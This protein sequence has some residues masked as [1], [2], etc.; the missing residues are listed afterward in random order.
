ML[1]STWRGI[2]K[3]TKVSFAAPCFI[4]LL[5]AQ[6]FAATPLHDWMMDDASGD[7]SLNWLNH[8]SA[9]IHRADAA[10]D[11]QS[12][13]TAIRAGLATN[14][15]QQIDLF[16]EN[17]QCAVSVKTF[18]AS[19]EGRYAKVIE[20][21][22][23]GHLPYQQTVNFGNDPIP[24]EFG[25]LHD[26]SHVHGSHDHASAHR[27]LDHDGHTHV[28]FDITSV[29]LGSNQSIGLKLHLNVSN[30]ANAHSF[31]L[32]GLGALVSVLSA[33]LL[34]AAERFMRR[35]QKAEEMSLEKAQY[36]AE[37]D[38]LTG[39]FN[40]YGFH[41]RA[42]QILEND[43]NLGAQ[44]Y[45]VI[46]D[47]D[48]FKEVNDQHGHETGDKVL[49]EVA[50]LLRDSY[51]KDALFGRLGGDE[52][53]VFA[54][55]VSHW[56]NVDN[57]IATRR[58]QLNL[59]LPHS[60][61]G[62]ETSVS[63]G[64]ARFPEHG[65]DLVDLMQAA[66]LALLEVKK[67]SKSTIGVYKAAMKERFE[68]RIWE[69]Q[70]VRLAA[71]TGQIEAHYQPIVSAQT[72]KICLFEALARWKHPTQGILPPGAFQSALDDP[73]VS[74][75]ITS[76]MLDCVAR[77]LKE[78]WGQNVKIPVSLN[79]GQADLKNPE[80]PDQMAAALDRYELPPSAL[81]VEVTETAVAASNM[82]NVLSVLDKIRT[83][84]IEI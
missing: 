60:D 59:N 75:L 14:A 70:G 1:A 34:F 80:L 40:R 84:D 28:I 82:A 73:I 11:Y 30:A 69:M 12:L 37:H 26:E 45:L 42:Q 53:A 24:F 72:S 77:D 68:R 64:Y 54:R 27:L 55:S 58:T 50:K 3:R 79:L 56:R 47:A 4:V 43:A 21:L 52:F 17:C 41:T 76:A 22:L 65:T 81:M 31:M 35:S 57:F 61:R 78:W 9:E 44:G 71:E 83:R 20:R 36:L 10:D 74:R 25:R 19:E 33:I 49:V 63:A 38:P 62:L 8:F 39:F 67:N 2:R 51:P 5:V 13:T 6:Y 23:K 15:L 46:Y 18:P 16:N 7:A 32:F 66:D 29:T 48:N